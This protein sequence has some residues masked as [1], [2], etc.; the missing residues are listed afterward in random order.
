LRKKKQ[1]VADPKI[2][3]RGFV[4]VK[5]N[6]DLMQES[7]QIIRKAV[8]NNLDNKEF[9]WGHLKQDV[10]EHLS[11]YLFEQTHRRPVILPVIME[12]NQ[13]HR[14]TTGKE[15]TPA[16]QAEATKTTKTPKAAKAPKSK[17]KPAP[18]KDAADK[19]AHKPHRNRKRRRTPKPATPE[20]DKA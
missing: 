7:A 11:H 14:R 8:Q 16:D 20:T 6:K 15:K 9:D 10:R 3:S 17:D 2:T 5:A 1:I 12:V 19:P 18:K 13:H 4:Y